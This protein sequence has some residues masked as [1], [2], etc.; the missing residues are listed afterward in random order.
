MFKPKLKRLPL[1]ALAIVVTILTA[2][3]ASAPP[4]A[5]NA[6]EVTYHYWSCCEYGV[7]TTSSLLGE[8]TIHCDNHVTRWGQITPYYTVDSVPCP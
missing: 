6:E 1:L 3:L 7:D 5:A 8:R 2:A 4:A